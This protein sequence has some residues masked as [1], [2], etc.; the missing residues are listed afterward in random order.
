MKINQVI[1]I[2]IIIFLAGYVVMDITDF[3]FKSNQTQVAGDETQ[4]E[5]NIQNQVQEQ[6]EINTQNVEDFDELQIETFREGSGE[7]TTQAGDTISIHYTGTLSNGQKFD[8]SLDS[9]QPFA[10][11]LGKGEV[12]PGFE[13]G[14]L[15]MQVGERRRIFIPSN[16]A[17]GEQGAGDG[18]IP[19]NAGLIFEVELMDIQQPTMTDE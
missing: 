4:T 6:T 3:K 11:T 16:L 15:D 13:Q 5:L 8:S 2:I 7:Q 9:G 14:L 19:P 18:I 12:I 1:L 10:F 17:Y